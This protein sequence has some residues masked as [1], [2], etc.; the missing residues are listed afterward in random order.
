MACE[1]FSKE[2]ARIHG[3]AQVAGQK[4]RRK[5]RGIYS[6]KVVFAAVVILVTADVDV[7]VDVD[8]DKDLEGVVE[9]V[10]EVVAGV[11]EI[12][13]ERLTST[14]LISPTPLTRLLTNNGLRLV[15][16]VFELISLRN[17]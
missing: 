12:V 11:S 7:D 1:Y 17:A 9:E 3:S 10:A 14:A 6:A 13:E 8:V 15:Q 4:N 2:V 5:Y 16:A